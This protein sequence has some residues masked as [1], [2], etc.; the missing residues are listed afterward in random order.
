V[1]TVY[2]TL[3]LCIPHAWYPDWLQH[4][5]HTF[6]RGVRSV[7]EDSVAVFDLGRMRHDVVLGG[8]LVLVA[9]VLPWVAMACLGRGRPSDIGLRMPNRYGWRILLVAYVASL[10]VVSW[11]VDSPDF[12]PYYLGHLRRGRTA[13]LT[14]YA[15]NMLAEHVLFHGVLLAALRRTGRW[16][17]HVPMHVGPGRPLGRTLQWIG[18]AQPVDR[19]GATMSSLWS[20][21]RR[22]I[23]LPDGCVAAVLLSGVLFAWMHVGKDLRE[24]A[25]SLPGGIAMAYVAYRT[26]SVL[27]P[28]LL[29]AATAGTACAMMVARYA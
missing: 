27:V 5:I 18:L 17:V 16:P 10:P 2:C 4:A 7:L 22:W 19:A 13:F 15:V 11:M 9:G 25:L 28:L 1:A 23:G 3:T 12:A 26:N 20:R 21:G 6:R 24:A 8:Y 29:H 14:F